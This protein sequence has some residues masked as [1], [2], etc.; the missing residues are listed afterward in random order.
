MNILIKNLITVIILCSTCCYAYDG[1]DIALM[2]DAAD[3]SNDAIRD[4][5][6]VIQRGDQKLI[7][8]MT[9]Q[10]Q[11]KGEGGS[12][13]LSLITFTEPKDLQDTKFLSKSYAD[14][15]QEKDLWVFLPAESLVRRISGGGRKN[16][17][18]R[19]DF[20]LEDL[21][22]RSVNEDNHR[23]IG[24]DRV[25]DRPV[26]IIESVPV[27]AKAEETGYGKRVLY[28]DQEYKL[29]VKVDYYNKY[30]R[31]IKTLMA[32]AFKNIQGIWT[33]TK[34][35]MTA[36]SGKCRT[37]LQYTG[38]TYNSGLSDEIFEQSNLKR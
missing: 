35:I 14:L 33:P 24:E 7:R 5:V 37:L 9:I 36:N 8:K 6:M 13:R 17:F 31:H 30:G 4:A 12:N 28:V 21:E 25:N 15:E 26:W 2:V 27:D 22:Y 11:K 1:R 16:A 32:G 10:L 23:F 29:P 19:S 38:I 20:S 3:T 18:M 34:L